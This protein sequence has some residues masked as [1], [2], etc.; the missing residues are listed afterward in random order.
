MLDQL[1]TLTLK[2]AL[3]SRTGFKTVSGAGSGPPPIVQSF[4]RGSLIALVCALGAPLTS[5]FQN[6][7]AVSNGHTISGRV[8]D[9]HQLHPED[10]TLMVGRPDGDGMSSRPIRIDANGSFVTERLGSDTYVLE[11]VG[12]PNSPTK[13]STTVGL[14]IVPLG[15]SDVSDVI[16]EVRSDTAITGTFR[17]ESDNPAAVWPPHIHVLADLALNEMTF[18][19]SRGADGAPGG[20]FVLRNAFGPRVLRCGYTL[21]PNSRWWPSQ[22]MLDG[23]DITNVPTDFSAHENGRLEV[24]F[25]QHPA[26]IRGTVTN[27]TTGR[28]V[29]AAW[30]L[31]AAADPALRQDRSSMLHEVQGN[32]RGEFS[33]AVTPGRYLVAAV[34][35]EKFVTYQA[36]RKDILRMTSGGLPVEVKTREIKDLN[37]RIQD[38]S[39]GPIVSPDDV[40]LKP[41]FELEHAPAKTRPL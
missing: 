21:A 33:V 31:V 18:L 8:I 15:T 5:A 26:R 29:P 9:P 11:L 28:P 41:Q 38:L 4:I 36:A 30:V 27:A 25:T 22:V 12:T 20:K 39:S 16:V 2:L 10:L 3:V 14:T 34:S 24:W 17:M 37:L 23:L 7:G 1:P 32:T 13:P 19:G 6:F 35:Q 40:R